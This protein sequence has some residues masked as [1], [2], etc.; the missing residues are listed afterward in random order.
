M[1]KLN[2]L[3]QLLVASYLIHASNASSPEA[4]LQGFDKLS[5]EEKKNSSKF[6]VNTIMY[7]PVPED[8]STES[9]GEEEDGEFKDLFD[10]DENNRKSFPFI[11]KN[12]GKVLEDRDVSSIEP[13]P[14]S[15]HVVPFLTKLQE[16]GF[17]N[18]DIYYLDN[19]IEIVIGLNRPKS[20][21][22][23]LNN[24]LIDE[25][26]SEKGNVLNNH[27]EKFGFFW[28]YIWRNK[29]NVEVDYEDVKSFYRQLK[30]KNAQKAKKF[31]EENENNVL[32]PY[33]QLR[34]RVKNHEYTKNFVNSL[35]QVS[36][37]FNIY[38]SFVDS[39]TI[40]FNGIYS[41]Y[42]EFISESEAPPT[43]LTT[44]YEFEGSVADGNYPFKIGSQID[45][46]IRIT[47]A[48]YIPLGVYYPEPNLCILLPSDAPTLPETFLDDRMTPEGSCEAA[49]LLRKIKIRPGFSCFFIN[50]KPI[51][52][53][54]PPRAKK[55]KNFGTSILFTD[56]FKQGGVPKDSDKKSLKSI[57]QSH[58]NEHVMY[59]NLY[60]NRAFHIHGT[61]SKLS[62][63]L[64][65][66][67]NRS[68]SSMNRKSKEDF[69]RRLLNNEVLISTL[70]L[71]FKE[72]KKETQTYFK[73]L[74]P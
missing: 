53:T 22:D 46:I 20:L 23:S 24:L 18:K 35:R 51:I 57:S 7:V 10:F 40:N 61:F 49:A 55:C 45:R 31:R 37:G 56:Q 69:L 12:I 70:D 11:T 4:L 17:E 50:S 34:E 72:V 21:S 74:N 30:K 15:K 3:F 25:L 47:I 44:G 60:I 14:E 39:D 66:M 43:V 68:F 48:K 16:K 58:Y 13:Y 64:S 26:S 52:T 9:S 42:L 63:L 36:L 2:I 29:E 1:H 67:F 19:S 27:Y 38:F 73:N 59:T 32:V 54:I 8:F 71:A 33:Q 62:S 5:V 41:T 28:H 6:L 65:K